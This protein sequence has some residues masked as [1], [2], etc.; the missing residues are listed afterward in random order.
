MYGEEAAH[1]SK[2]NAEIGFQ[3]EKE[4]MQAAPGEAASKSDTG[5]GTSSDDEISN[6]ETS[7]SPSFASSLAETFEDIEPWVDWLRRAAS[8]IGTVM[9]DF[10]SDDWIMIPRRR[11]WRFAS[12]IAKCGDQ[13]RSTRFVFGDL[14]TVLEEAADARTHVGKM[15]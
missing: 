4:K 13:R 9:S 1:N 10:H 2:E 11:K 3:S 15:I 8:H 7:C 14:G 5:S 6:D 12:Q